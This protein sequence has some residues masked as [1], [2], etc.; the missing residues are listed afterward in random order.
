MVAYRDDDAADENVEE[1]Q[2]N[3]KESEGE[4]GSGCFMIV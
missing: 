3:S 1:Q 2:K 4:G